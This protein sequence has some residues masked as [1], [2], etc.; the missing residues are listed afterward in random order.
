MLSFSVFLML[1]DGPKVTEAELQLVSLI[2]VRHQ[3]SEFHH[4][5]REKKWKQIRSK[6]FDGFKFGAAT[7]KLNVEKVT[8]P[9]LDHPPSVK[10]FYVCKNIHI[11]ESCPESDRSP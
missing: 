11:F 9:R 3:K 1:P 4:Q 10:G 7:F 6:M 2:T 8:A 5:V